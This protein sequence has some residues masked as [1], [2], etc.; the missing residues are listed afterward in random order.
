MIRYDFKFRNLIFSRHMVV[1]VRKDGTEPPFNLGIVE[2]VGK[3]WKSALSAKYRKEPFK[4]REPLAR[5]MLDEHWTKTD[6]EPWMTRYTMEVMRNMEHGCEKF[7][8][9]QAN[10]IYDILVEEC[11]ADPRLNGCGRPNFIH[12]MTDAPLRGCEYRFCGALGSGG[13]FWVNRNSIQVNCYS[14]DLDAEAKR[15]IA[16]A[17]N[18]LQDYYL[19]NLALKEPRT[20]SEIALESVMRDN[21]AIH[22]GT[23]SDKHRFS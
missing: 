12:W 18:R 11:D 9:A 5:A 20:I 21:D 8:E 3:E 6:Y 7:T 13:K 23:A 2:K 10:A 1:V 14:E 22:D 15:T 16:R 19:A 4:T 17:N